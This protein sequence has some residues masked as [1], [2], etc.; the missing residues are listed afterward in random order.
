MAQ[1]CDCSVNQINAKVA[2]FNAFYTL[3]FALIFIFT[4]YK[5]IIYVLVVDFAIKVIFRPKYSPISQLNMR[6]LK[7]FKVAPEMIF[8]APKIFA[9]KIG[10]T[11][12]LAGMILHLF[13][14]DLA[15][16]IVISILAFFAFLEAFFGFCMGCWAHSYY[17]KI[18]KKSTLPS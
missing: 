18:F 10:L 17:I 8:A 3:A 11:F 13:G 4:P 15:A 7:L 9:L 2:R 14:L 6:I 1:A 16:L 5:W 12:S